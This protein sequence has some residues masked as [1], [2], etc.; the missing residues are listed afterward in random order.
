MVLVYLVVSGGL[1]WKENGSSLGRKQKGCGLEIFSYSSTLP[2]ASVKNFDFL[3]LQFYLYS[4]VRKRA[5]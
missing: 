2:L 4:F 1:S 5:D 3:R